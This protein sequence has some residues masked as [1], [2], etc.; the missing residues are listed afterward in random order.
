MKK[1][2]HF[3]GKA[4]MRKWTRVLWSAKTLKSISHLYAN[5]T[6]HHYQLKRFTLSG[7]KHQALCILPKLCVHAS[8]CREASHHYT[9]TTL[10][11][12]SFPDLSFRRQSTM[13]EYKGVDWEVKFILC[14]MLAT[15]GCITITSQ[16]DAS[17]IMAIYHCCCCCYCGSVLASYL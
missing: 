1:E 3:G 15:L 14:V 5:N 9:F 11:F 17:L 6:N 16:H 12:I 8:T 2:R 4:E 13:Y 10:V 7:Q